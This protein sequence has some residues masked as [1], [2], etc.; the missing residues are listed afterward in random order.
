MSGY[1]PCDPEEVFELADGALSPEREQE[2]RAHLAACPPCRRLYEN[3]LRLN[4]TLSSL[5]S[6][7]PPCRSVRKGVA[8]ALPTR[9]WK[10][11]IAWVA[12]ALTLLIAASLALSLD[13]ATP[14]TLAVNAV[15][16]FWGIVSGFADVVRAVLSAAGPTLAVALAIGALAD[17]CIAAAVLFAT[18]RRLRQA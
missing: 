15:G 17:L 1:R 3:E 12:V 18:R 14:A 16:F 5:R 10:V 11:R 7:E 9:A 8:M 4:F 6:A 13:G 2:A